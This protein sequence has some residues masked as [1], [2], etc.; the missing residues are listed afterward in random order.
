MQ[1][2]AKLFSLLVIIPLTIALLCFNHCNTEKNKNEKAKNSYQEVRKINVKIN[3]SQTFEIRQIKK[4]LTQS[5]IFIKG[6]GFSNRRNAIALKNKKPIKEIFVSDIN[7]DGYEELYIIIESGK[8]HPISEIIGIT[9][10][11]NDSYKLIYIPEFDK[12]TSFEFNYLKNYNGYDS[13]YIENQQLFRTFPSYN[14]V[15]KEYDTHNMVKLNY[16]LINMNNSFSLQ[17]VVI[18]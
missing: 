14:S 6:I 1:F 17:A 9:I 12:N 5:D 10:Q 4:G 16:K 8:K 2:K 11:E 15:K 7:A 13:I 3:F 18:N